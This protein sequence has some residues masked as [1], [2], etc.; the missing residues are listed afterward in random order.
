MKAELWKNSRDGVAPINAI[1]AELEERQLFELSNLIHTIADKSVK[2]LAELRDSFNKDICPC[3]YMALTDMSHF[4]QACADRIPQ[5]IENKYE[6]LRDKLL[7]SALMI[8]KGE[9]AWKQTSEADRQQAL[10]DLKWKERQLNEQGSQ[11]EAVEVIKRCLG[12]EQIYRRFLTDDNLT[13]VDV[14]EYITVKRQQE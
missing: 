12:N 7:M 9:A 14:L 3:V 13:G 4:Y 2:D 6:T 10:Q 1:L 11:H 5:A 8:Q